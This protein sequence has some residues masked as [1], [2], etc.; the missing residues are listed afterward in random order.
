MPVLC[1]AVNRR[2]TVIS[3]TAIRRDREK[4][5]LSRV[6]LA[7]LADVDPRTIERIEAGEVTPRRATLACIRRVLDS[8]DPED[9]PA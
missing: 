7:Y 5:G 3:G 4:V 2:A 1:R 8:Y 9:I 6:G